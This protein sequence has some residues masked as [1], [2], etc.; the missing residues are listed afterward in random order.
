[1]TDDLISRQAV[2]DCFKKWQ[3]YM[4]T[5]IWDFEQEL[6]A[7]PSVNPQEPKWDRL[8]SWLNDMRYGIAPDE[9]TPDDE[10]REREAQVDVIDDIMEW[11]EKHPQEPKTGHWSHD[12]S[13]WKNRF[14]CSECGYKLFEEQT[15][16]CPN[17][18]CRMVEPQES[19]EV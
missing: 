1:M 11:I 5:R 4:A 6:S 17:C 14:I 8:Y 2:M 16:Y 15:N 18:G 9:N 7:L 10:R 12:G 3:P 13:H 19:E